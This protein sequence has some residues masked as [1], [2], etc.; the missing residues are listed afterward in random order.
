LQLLT[1]HHE[2]AKLSAE[3][4]EKGDEKGV[5]AEITKLET[6]LSDL[7]KSFQVS[8]QD[9]LNF[10]KAS[11]L[12]QRE[13]RIIK[14]LDATKEKLSN[15]QSVI[16]ELAIDA[17]DFLAFKEPISDA[18]NSAVQAADTKW[19]A[20]RDNILSKIDETN[21]EFAEKLA[22][23][24]A[25]ITEL[26]P[27]ISGHG[28]IAQLTSLIADE[29]QKLS[30]ILDLGDKIKVQNNTFA[31]ISQD[32]CNSFIRFRQILD[33]YA[34]KINTRLQSLPTDDLEFRVDVV[35]RS[36][37][38]KNYLSKILNNKT[39]AYF[40][41]KEILL[42]PAEENITTE[43]LKD[44][45][46]S[47]LSSS[48][49]SLNLKSD[50]SIEAGLREVFVNWYNINYIVKLDND[51][52]YAMSPGKKAL[53]LLRLLISL[54][55]SKCPILIDQPEDDLDNR[56][57]FG[58]LIE[59]IKKRKTDRQIIV[60]THNAN[61]VVGSDAELVIVANQDGKNSP[62][63]KYRFEYCSGSIESNS[64]PPKKDEATGILELQR[65][66]GHICDILEGGLTAFELRGKKYKSLSETH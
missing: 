17:E 29:K 66:Q 56:S 63:S 43:F 58:E 35:F 36:E 44:L 54:A 37:H 49:Q 61:I 40:V 3:R 14:A 55:E 12:V 57:I 42:D 10:Q 28:Q 32:I 50:Y 25:V 1:T 19:Q 65:I 26:Q 30:T 8:E 47:L 15:T 34:Q 59:F 4:A 27:K 7:S 16:G 5:T 38:F 11:E 62:N 51:D 41:H 39:Y 31:S 21:L 33:D 6:Q 24:Q 60:V 18:I 48:Q 64:P 22:K 45:V 52:I 53:V 23:N 46:S 2:I 20:E 13:T 9:I